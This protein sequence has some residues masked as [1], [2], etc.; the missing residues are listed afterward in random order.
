MTEVTDPDT[1]GPTAAGPGPAGPGSG[2]PGSGGPGPDGQRDAAPARAVLEPRRFAA[3]WRSLSTIGRTG[4]GYHRLAYA[5]AEMEC[6]EWFAEEAI[7]RDLAL[8]TDRNGNMWA[9]L[10]DPNVGGAIVT[11]SHFDTIPGGGGYDGALGIVS[12]FLALDLLDMRQAIPTRPIGVVAFAGEEGARFGMA[13]LGSRLMTGTLDPARAAGLSDRDGTTLA[14][15]MSLAG[16][17]PAGMGADTARV[18]AIDA[19]VELHIEQGRTLEAPVGVVGSVWPYGRWR[20]DITG[21]GNH[22]GTTAMSDRDDPMLT[23]AFAVLAANKEARLRGGHASIG[24]LSARPNAANAIP[25]RVTCWLD[26]RAPTESTVDEM[27]A[28]LATKVGERA[29]RD[30][31][32]VRFVEEAR[33][34]PVTFDRR[35]RDRWTGLLDAPV[36]TSSAGHDAGI[37]AA[38]LPAGMLFVRNPTGVSHAPEEHAT[39]DDCAA[40]VT[41]LADVLEDLACQ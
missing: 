29:G 5:S 39:D 18:A 7:D 41:A 13:G 6:R 16:L 1:T 9:W 10:G 23:A 19:F 12:A 34:A 20:V 21:T 17:D 26:A 32:R 2:G 40:G 11:G 28:A 14:E 31:T 4:S 30:G 24:R 8:E 27:V 33:F 3:L 25:S 22:S 36:L 35:L 38:H 37:L 15:A